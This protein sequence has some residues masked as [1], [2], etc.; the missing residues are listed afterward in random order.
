M[1]T[2]HC[3]ENHTAENL[4]AEHLVAFKEWGIENKNISGCVDNARNLMGKT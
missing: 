2:R 3:P 4:R 1:Q